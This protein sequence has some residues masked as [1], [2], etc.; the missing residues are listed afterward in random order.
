ML[1]VFLKDK[2]EG[3]REAAAEGFGRLRN[4]A[5]VP[6]IQAAYND[7]AKRPVRVALAFALVMDG[8]TELSES[9]PLQYLINM[10]N[11]AA[12]KNDAE[13]FLIE[14]AKDPAIQAKLYAPMENGTK[15]EKIGLVHVM[16]KSGIKAAEAHVEVISRDP[17]KQVAEEG[18]R[19][20]RNL[21]ARL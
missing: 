20:L 7:E 13:R 8:Q 16:A 4:P 9:S 14:I 15:D 11:Q 12:N 17:D 19:A 18:L 2:D 3:M 6:V 21:R 5:D 10:L 1:T